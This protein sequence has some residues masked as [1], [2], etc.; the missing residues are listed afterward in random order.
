[1]TLFSILAQNVITT[2]GLLIG[3]GQFLLKI[4]TQH[5]WVYNRSPLYI[6]QLFVYIRTDIHNLRFSHARHTPAN[7]PP[8]YQIRFSST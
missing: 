5:L 1:M 7:F 8:E 2:S 4:K 3:V 6:F